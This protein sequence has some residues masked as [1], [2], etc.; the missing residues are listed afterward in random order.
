[1]APRPRTLIDKIWD[2]HC[3]AQ[4]DESTA[5]LHVDRIMLHD[6]SGGTTLRSLRENGRAVV[7]PERVFGTYDHIVDTH[8]GRGRTSRMPG[9]HEF[10]ELLRTEA[11]R[12]R[13]RTFDI[14]D[15]RQGIVH[16]IAP[17]LGIAL[18]GITLACGDSH[19]P[20]LGGIGALAFGVGS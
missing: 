13:I 5:L 2:A 17:E 8:P 14:G 6:R 19:T 3:I 7:R 16:V 10:I 1:A 20:T 15:P 12:A 11:E 4:L 18:P 9:G